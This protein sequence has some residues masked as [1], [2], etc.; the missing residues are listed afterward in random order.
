MNTITQPNPDDDSEEMLMLP[1]PEVGTHY[2]GS[3]PQA[4]PGMFW[5]IVLQIGGEGNPP[6]HLEIGYY[7]VI[8]RG[9]PSEGYIPQIDFTAFGAKDFGI[10]RRHATLTP[11]AEGLLLCDLNSLNGTFVNGVSLQA[12]EP[13]RLQP[14]DE[15]RFG[16]LRMI[17]RNLRPVGLSQTSLL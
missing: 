9:D 5:E 2:L 1:P 15:I 14:G 12:N 16:S 10:S 11:D 3:T 13:R 4:V 7:S 17:I 6:V 8:G